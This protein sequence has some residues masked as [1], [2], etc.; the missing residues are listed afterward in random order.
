[1]SEGSSEQQPD[2]VNKNESDIPEGLSLAD[3][4]ELSQPGGHFRDELVKKFGDKPV[5]DIFQ[6]KIADK[7]R[8]LE[9][10]IS[11]FKVMILDLK[12]VVASFQRINDGTSHLTASE[13][14]LAAKYMITN[15]SSAVQR[16]HAFRI[17]LR[18][19]EESLRELL[20]SSDIELAQHKFIAKNNPPLNSFMKGSKADH[21]S[22]WDME[23]GGFKKQH[24]F[25]SREINNRRERVQLLNQG[26]EALRVKSIFTWK[27]EGK[28]NAL[29][30]EIGGIML[31]LE[32]M[33]A[34]QK[35]IEDELR[36]Y[37]VE[38]PKE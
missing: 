35:D 30:A 3:A 22:G 28:M 24:D 25:L 18:Q 36:T 29:R 38:L 4:K 7:K 6:Q 21:A 12:D 9:K 8:G 32:K 16:L 33:I 19:S 5:E 2:K 23:I 20:E 26:V 34:K 1:M 10:V 11:K 27:K 17:Q 15:L 14:D 37:G 13:G 31:E